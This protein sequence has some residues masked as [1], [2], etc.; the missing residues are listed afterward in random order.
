MIASDPEFCPNRCE[1][2]RRKFFQGITMASRRTEI[3]IEKIIASCDGNTRGALEALMLVN[4]HLEAELN[5][6]YTV[7]SCIDDTD[8]CFETLH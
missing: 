1:I 7:I 2:W 8:V 6:L 3:A 4:E 5:R